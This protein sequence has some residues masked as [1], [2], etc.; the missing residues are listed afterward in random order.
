MQHEIEELCE[1]DVFETEQVEEDPRFKICNREAL[2][3]GILAVAFFLTLIIVGQELGNVDASEITL[4]AGLPNWFFYSVLL[5]PA[6]FITLLAF[7][8]KFFFTD[9]SLD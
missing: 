5:V 8:I 2:I 3:C 9:L 7:I 1:K 4:V 6:G